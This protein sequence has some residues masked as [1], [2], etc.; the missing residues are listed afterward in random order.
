MNDKQIREG[1]SRITDGV[2]LDLGRMTIK[3]SGTNKLIVTAWMN[4]LHFKNINK[5]SVLKELDSL[6]KSFS[7]LTKTHNDLMSVIRD[8]NLMVEYH[9]NYD[10]SGKAGIGLCSEINGELNWYL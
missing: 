3:T 2:P 7:E 8:N 4:T 10:D 1:I 6:K 9:L 5:N